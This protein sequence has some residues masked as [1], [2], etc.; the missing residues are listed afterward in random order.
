V[1]ERHAAETGCAATDVG[2]LDLED[3]RF[4][5]EGCGHRTNYKCETAPLIVVR[6]TAETPV[7]R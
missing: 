6:C 3:D 1:R 5:A 7:V 2:T 4:T